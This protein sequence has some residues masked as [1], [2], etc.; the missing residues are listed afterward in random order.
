MAA[1]DVH[2]EFPTTHHTGF[3]PCEFTRRAEMVMHST[4]E[5]NN[6]ALTVWYGGGLPMHVV[7]LGAFTPSE[8]VRRQTFFNVSISRFSAP[9]DEDSRK[10]IPNPMKN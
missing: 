10:V 4:E 3:Q 6:E 9:L 2:P 1:G 7:V 8:G 5:P